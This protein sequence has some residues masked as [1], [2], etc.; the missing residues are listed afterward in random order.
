MHIRVDRTEVQLYKIKPMSSMIANAL[1]RNKAVVIN[2]FIYPSIHPNTKTHPN[3][4][5]ST[6]VNFDLPVDPMHL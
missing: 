2:S 3:K 1:K 6:R 5:N 4:S